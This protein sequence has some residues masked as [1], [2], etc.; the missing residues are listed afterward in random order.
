MWNAC[1]VSQPSIYSKPH[2][3]CVAYL[4]SLRVWTSI[5]ADTMLLCSFIDQ[6]T[7]TV[8]APLRTIS[9]I[10]CTVVRRSLIGSTRVPVFVLFFHPHVDDDDD[11]DD[12]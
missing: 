2:C 5:S 3:E 7:R 12:D 1:A 8:L 6:Y 11:D 10:C 4:G 9:M